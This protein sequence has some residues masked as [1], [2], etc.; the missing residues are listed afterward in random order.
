[1][2]DMELVPLKFLNFNPIYLCCLSLVSEMIALILHVFTNVSTRPE[3]VAKATVEALGR[4]VPP[5]VQGV[6]FLSGGQGEESATVH[7]NAI[8][9]TTLRKPWAL[10]FSYGRALQVS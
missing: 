3:E 9:K 1:M 5:A 7:L 2:Y 4:T 10:T 8:N 6:V